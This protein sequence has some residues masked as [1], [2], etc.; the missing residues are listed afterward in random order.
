[1]THT[2]QHQK[3]NSSIKKWAEDLNRRFFQGGNADGR[4]A[5][6]RIHIIANHLG[7]EQ[8]NHNEKAPPNLSEWPSSKRTQV[9]NVEENVEKR[10]L[11]Y[12]VSGNAN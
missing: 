3:P 4:Q 2:T 9:T 1:M 8:Q 11:V 5:H 6:E 12:I 7:D 10:V